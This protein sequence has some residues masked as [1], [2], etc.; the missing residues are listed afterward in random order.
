MAGIASGIADPLP[1]PDF[2][3]INEAGGRRYAQDS[4][5][6]NTA[7]LI[8]AITSRP[9]S[10]HI[11]IYFPAGTWR[12]STAD[13]FAQLSAAQLANVPRLSFV[14]A[15]PEP[16]TQGTAEHNLEF[17]TTIEF[18]GS[19]WSDVW[20]QRLSDGT[21]AEFFGPLHFENIAFSIPSGGKGQFMKFAE[22]GT[23]TAG[24]TPG[25]P[26]FR[27]LTIRNCA[28]YNTNTTAQS[29]FENGGAGV[30]WINKA[31]TD[32]TAVEITHGYNV[33]IEG[34]NFRRFRWPLKLIAADCPSL[35]DNKY[36]ACGHGPLITSDGYTKVPGT[37][38]P[39]EY[40][41]NPYFV[42]LVSDC[43]SIVGYSSE[44]GYAGSSPDVGAYDLDESGI[45]WS[46][47]A[48][49]DRIELDN[50]PSGKDATDYLEPWT[51]I[52]VDPTGMGQDSEP[53]REYVIKDV[54]ATGAD[55]LFAGVSGS[56]AQPCNAPATISGGDTDLI[57]LYGVNAI[58]AGDNMTVTAP[59]HGRNV[60]LTALGSV[61]ASVPL[62]AVAPRAQGLT[63]AGTLGGH[64]TADTPIV[65]RH[66][67][68]GSGFVL[69]HVKQFA[70]NDLLY[71]PS[72]VSDDRQ[73]EYGANASVYP[74]S[75]NLFAPDGNPYTVLCGPL[76]GG[77][78]TAN[79][80]PGELF[81]RRATATD[82][83]LRDGQD[84]PWVWRLADITSVG[85][86]TLSLPTYAGVTL[87]ARIY[88][89]SSK[90]NGFR[91]EDGV[92]TNQ[93]DIAS[94]W[95][96]VTLTLNASATRARLNNT[97]ADASANNIE[98]AWIGVRTNDF[99]RTSSTPTT[100]D[101]PTG[102]KGWHY[103]TSSGA[104]TLCA[105]PAG[106]LKTV[107]LS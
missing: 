51:L 77:F 94:G 49:T 19:A 80:S 64:Y 7:A 42:G 62:Y 60:S 13:F 27:G 83:A 34:C 41:E 55:L 70:G 99:V 63:I 88:A 54:D 89:P 33:K 76:Y 46:I 30:G 91:I 6:D 78:T 22:D 103:N 61:S 65:V 69:G 37:I 12:F 11:A 25:A 31:D 67:A 82:D 75:Y 44:T 18:N 84:E 56:D 85:Y 81:Y 101:F 90:T 20:L 17:A 98:V 95:Q 4:S 40:V 79:G 26:A 24:L 43:G 106:T 21:T 104:V 36:Y 29:W 2:V 32:T 73:P 38:G 16:Q 52:R 92:G 74:P 93:T 1:R 48:D 45:T 10:Q 71:H 68:G 102:E 105:N 72:V 14:G 57:R 59:R 87:F 3:F 53:T 39:K 47:T 107:A 96:T 58:Y 9:D 15:S 28:F 100:T 8:R 66:H 86:L 50:F 97:A 5:Y 23:I 35:I